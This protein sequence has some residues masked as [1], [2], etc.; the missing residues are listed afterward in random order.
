MDTRIAD[1]IVLAVLALVGFWGWRRGTLL[2]ALSLGGLVA[3]YVGAFLFYRPVGSLL[4]DKTGMP[5]VLAYPMAGILLWLVIGAVLNLV[6]RKARKIRKAKRAEG[7]T[8]SRLDSAGGAWMGVMLAF[9]VSSVV[10]W[11]MMGIHSFAGRG[12][13]VA[14]TITARTTSVVAERIV[15]VAARQITKERVLASA[16]SVVAANPAAGTQTIRTVIQDERFVR[17]L[18]DERLREKLARGDVEGLS[19]SEA[20]SGLA[21]D[22]DF[23]EAAARLALVGPDPG[24][25]PGMAADLVEGLAPMAGT[26]EMLLDD[27]E[28]RTL[29][30][31]GDLLER[32]QSGDIRSLATDADFNRLAAKVLGL[33]RNG[34]GEGDGS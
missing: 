21:G 34:A 3:G 14:S 12:P 22:V 33:L 18:S 11:T 17:L 13:D 26:I 31:D 6:Q 25:G 23:L 15:Y 2:M 32:I 24:A 20:L 9:G 8:P 1:V 7:W 16:M 27:D 29:L 19:G 4:L 28:I 30:E 5:P 10:V